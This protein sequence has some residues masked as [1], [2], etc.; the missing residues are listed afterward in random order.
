MEVVGSSRLVE[1]SWWTVAGLVLVMWSLQLFSLV[2]TFPW[3]ALATIGSGLWGIGTMSCAWIVGDHQ[4]GRA[5]RRLTAVATL[6]ITLGMLAV[7]SYGQVRVAPAY[8]TD[9]IAFDQYAA[10]LALH[11]HDPYRHSMSPSF[12]R[13]QVSPDAYTYKLDGQPVTSL[14]Y[15]ALAFEVYLPFLALGW[16]TQLAVAVNV[17]AW[18]AA[19]A[20]MF[21]VLPRRLKPMALVLGS[22]GVYVGYAVGGVTDAVF[23]PLLIGAAVGWNRFP[24]RRGFRCL[25]G[26]LLLGLAMAVKQTPWV[27]L[28]FVV[29]GI[30]IES[31]AAAGRRRAASDG[32]RYLLI[33][34]LGFLIPNLPFLVAG[35]GSWVRGLLTPVVGHAVPAGQG[36]VGLSLFLGLGGGSLTWY[37]TTAFLL[38][39]ALWLVYVAY[40]RSLRPLAFFVPAIVLFFSARSFGSYLVTVVPAGIVAATT[41]DHSR[42]AALRPFALRWRILGPLS[43]V[44]PVTTAALALLSPPPLSLKVVGIRTTGQLATVEQV[45][46][47]VRNRTGHPVSPTFS[48]G[49]GGSITTFWGASGGP[50]ALGPHQLA[51]YELRSPNFGAMPSLGSGFQVDAF[52]S[53]PAAVAVSSAYLTSNLRVGLQ[54]AAVNTPVPV[55][56]AVTVRARL[57]NA[58]DR[59]VHA[60]DVPIYLGQIIYDEQGLEYAQAVINSGQVGQTPVMALT[61]GQGVATFIIRGTRTGP[62][63]VYFEA[64]L[65]NPTYFYPY[66]YSVILP[67]RFV[68]P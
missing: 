23:A 9:E 46:V 33:S 10:T 26:P 34:L 6:L 65:V 24:V 53:S 68:T 66:G 47:A 13:Y 19:I 37:T 67:I 22:L 36:V 3:M 30:V 60:A 52:I 1:R 51:S 29:A 38:M 62:D 32:A 31:N 28:P 35:P 56:R 16:S 8:A 58:L 2:S 50:A 12:D 61:N 4:F 64:N 57:L 44:L 18:M 27:I 17:L 49:E 59:P 7:W 11:G 45:E 41:L 14:S 43:A 5:V 39:V 21:L 55:G 15:P 54:P 20:L 63:P 42:D 25:M 48:I 40:Y